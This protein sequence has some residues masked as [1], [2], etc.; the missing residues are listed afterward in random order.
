MAEALADCP[1]CGA[2]GAVTTLVAISTAGAVGRLEG[3][4]GVR[5]TVPASVCRDCA[6]M[7]I[8]VRPRP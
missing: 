4:T 2:T 8:T 1:T 6:A 3:I 5:L 7:V